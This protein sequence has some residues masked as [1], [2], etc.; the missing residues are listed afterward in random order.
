MI[1]VSRKRWRTIGWIV[2]ERDQ[3]AVWQRDES[4]A[5]DV[6]ERVVRPRKRGRG[7]D[8][9]LIDELTRSNAR[10]A[11]S[12]KRHGTPNERDEAVGHLA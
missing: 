1:I 2:V 7:A 10:E 5:V 8:D 11:R 6:D 4:E 3:R 12:G 9:A